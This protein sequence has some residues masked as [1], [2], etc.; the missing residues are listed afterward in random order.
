MISISFYFKKFEKIQFNRCFVGISNVLY[1]LYTVYTVH[2]LGCSTDAFKISRK[3]LQLIINDDLLRIMKYV[4]V[5]SSVL[6]EYFT[7]RLIN[8]TF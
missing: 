1:S 2:L 6:I 8:I 3:C 5:L 4:L 7:K